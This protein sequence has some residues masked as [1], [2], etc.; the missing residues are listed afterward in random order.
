MSARTQD[1]AARA[2]DRATRARAQREFDAPLAVEAGA[3]TGKT[4]VLIARILAWCLGV[5]WERA[6]ARLKA[7]AP[8]PAPVLPEHVA[9]EV[10]SRVAA[11]TFTVAAAA[12]M[13]ERLMGG[14]LGVVRGTAVTGFDAQALAATPEEK[15]ARARALLDASDQISIQTIHAFCLR[16]LN[17]HPLAIGLHP[18]LTV[19]TDETLCDEVAQQVVE[20]FC[21]SAYRDENSDAFQLALAAEIAPQN[22]KDALFALLTA[23]AQSENLQ[24][25]LAPARIKRWREALLPLLDDFVARAGALKGLSGRPKQRALLEALPVLRDSVRRLTPSRDA[26]LLLAATAQEQLGEHIERGRLKEWARGKQGPCTDDDPC[27]LGAEREPLRACIARFAPF[28]DALVTTDFTQLE[29]TSRVLHALLEEARAELKRRG[30][31][32]YS[33]MLRDAERLLREHPD[34]RARV[35]ESYDQLLVDEFQDTDALQCEILRHLTQGEGGPTLFLVGDP[36]QSIYGWRNADLAAYQDF[37]AELLPRDETPGV[38]CENFRSVQPLLDEVERCLEPIFGA[39]GG[40]LRPPFQKLLVS[41]ANAKHA[42]V[43]DG[44]AAPVEH[45]LSL[46]FENNGK[47]AEKTRSAEATRIEAQAL[48]ADIARQVAAGVAP[49]DF[50][51]LLRTTGSLDVVLGALRDAG[52]DYVVERDQSYYRRREVIDATALLRWLLDPHDHVAFAAV[53]RSSLV[54]APDAA[55]LP[56]WRA[57]FPEHAGALY[58][59]VNEKLAQLQ[60]RARAIEVP[61]D[62]PGISRIEGWR[63][64]LAGLLALAGPLRAA[65][66]ERAPGRFVELLRRAL[67]LEAS[68]AARS[69]GRFRLANLDRFFRILA[70]NLERQDLAGLLRALRG[71]VSSAREEEEG[72]PRTPDENAV[73]VMTIHKAKGLDFE[74]VYLLQTHKGG[75][76]SE[77]KR[78]AVLRHRGAEALVL[79]GQRSL[80]APALAQVQQEREALERERVLYVALTRAKKRL[81][82][83]GL[84]ASAA[85]RE[86]SLATLL[87][88]RS[89]RPSVDALLVAAAGDGTAAKDFVDRGG[90]RWVFPALRAAASTARTKTARVELSIARAREDA[91]RIRERRARAKLRMARPAHATASAEHAARADEAAEQSAARETSELA[92]SPEVLFAQADDGAR[93]TN[94]PR[95]ASKSPARKSAGADEETRS[96]FVALRAG[97]AVHA[98][99]E[100]YDPSAGADGRAAAQK[101]LES[102]LCDEA[103]AD[104]PAHTRARKLWKTFLAGALHEKFCAIAPNI[105][106]RELPLLAPPHANAQ[107]AGAPLHFV[108]GVVDLLY[109]EPESGAWVVADYKTDEVANAAAAQTRAAHYAA[110]G[111]FYCHALAAALKLSETPRFELWFLAAG[112]VVTVPLT[113]DK[114]R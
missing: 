58:G 22:W 66:D 33:A 101:M 52:L 44:D 109:R 77:A 13:A 35:R 11:I 54:G 105:V 107:G 94:E 48:A 24:D 100:F 42:G 85:A 55:L 47:P 21:A 68:E 95:A 103:D 92:P 65:A 17:A 14:L 40:A 36:K 79:F 96:D 75:A 97:S 19:D 53:L 10:L 72:R 113:D 45:W 112:L 32:S 87:A 80:E 74:Q 61:A 43:S 89:E 69:L 78:S 27:G 110:Q 38:L 108:T 18:R 91:R 88:K 8:S 67:L 99:L 98:A 70:E 71:A 28:V 64:N 57:N 86:E 59:D 6:H 81:V 16:L 31:Q 3:G 29:Q 1:A 12:E 2:F 62:V 82:I 63:E 15:K 56:L 114:T 9:R 5:G 102:A 49:R 93:K 76:H 51:I 104:G 25:V 83:A 39:G 90:A 30:I 106:A 60:T 50:G 34:I 84:P 20:R 26:F 111:A 46:K 4:A 23:S 7:A 73:Q 37:I 41:E